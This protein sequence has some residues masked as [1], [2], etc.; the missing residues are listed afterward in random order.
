M[1]A[2]EMFLFLK[3]V[4]RA[5]DSAWYVL[6]LRVLRMDFKVRYSPVSRQKKSELKK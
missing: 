3:A 4:S 6:A 1:S 5:S 2:S